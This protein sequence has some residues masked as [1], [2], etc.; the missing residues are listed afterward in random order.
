MRIEYC[1]TFSV[2]NWKALPLSKKKEHTMTKCSACA[3][4]YFELQMKFPGLPC[5]EP[6][7]IVTLN[8]PDASKVNDSTVTRKVL[9]LNG[10]FKSERN[11]SF[12]D[13]MVKHCSKSEGV[14]KKESKTKQ[15]SKQRKFTK[16]ALK[17]QKLL[18]KKRL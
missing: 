2:T 16:Y 10:S 11:Q 9:Q 5:F 7:S 3:T 12:T 18:Q 8:I 1:R 17:S 14:V 4:E 6:E 13:L 15:K